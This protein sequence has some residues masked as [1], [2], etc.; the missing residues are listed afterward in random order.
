MQKK[1]E[2]NLKKQDL[3]VDS[4]PVKQVL[5]NLSSPFL[6][7][8]LLEIKILK[9]VIFCLWQGHSSISACAKDHQF[10]KTTML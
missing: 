1:S 6:I 5:V 7:D 9:E 4:K 10:F 8:N 2:I 3:H